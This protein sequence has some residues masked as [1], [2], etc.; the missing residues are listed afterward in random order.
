M[1]RFS[2]KVYNFMVNTV[3][4]RQRQS[5]NIQHFQLVRQV[6]WVQLVQEDR[7]YR[8]VQQDQG[9]R[10]GPCFPRGWGLRVYQV[11]QEPP[12]D[13]VIHLGLYLQSHQLGQS[14]PTR[15][16]GSCDHKIISFFTMS[17]LS[18]KGVCVKSH[19]GSDTI[20]CYSGI[21]SLM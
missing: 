5:S 20:N 3:L 8:E 7:D 2:I 14:H 11:C 9:V 17:L 21:S 13:Q 4:Y 1:R 6:P 18:C 15:Y 19:E 10:Q 16:G 12:G